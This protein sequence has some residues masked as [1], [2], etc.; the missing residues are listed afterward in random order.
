MKIKD[1]EITM[2]PAGEGDCIVVYFED[3]NYRILIDGGV[4]STYEEN[5]RPYLQK[6][7]SLE[8][9]ID[10]IVVTHIDHDHLG[11]IIR[12]LKENGKADNPSLISIDEI[13]FNGLSQL[14]KKITNADIIPQAEKG[15]LLG[16]AA[17]NC[18]TR[19]ESSGTRDISFSQGE[20]LS[21]LIINNGYAWNRAFNYMPV[22]KGSTVRIGDI[23][24]TI[25][26]PTINTLK[27]LYEKWIGELK[28]RCSNVVVTD[29]ILY[30]SAFE[31]F[32]LYE[33]DD[34]I[35]FHT[36][37]S[38]IKN[39]NWEKEAEKEDDGVDSSL[40][41]KSSIVMRIEYKG[42]YLLFPGD[43]PIRSIADELPE[44]LDVVKLPHHGSGRSIDKN[45]IKNKKV[46]YYLLSTNGKKHNHP[47]K[48]IIGNVLLYSKIETQIIKNYNLEVL[49]N[50][51]VLEDG[52]E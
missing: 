9:K 32:Y 36:I 48:T 27:K 26:N 11:G 25:L 8:Q 30:D 51:G 45:F 44:Y 5:L 39:I 14:P 16:M 35:Q 12:L 42:H 7:S 21:E 17:N 1:I 24:I 41:N 18:L 46:S 37:S 22:I 4:S 38:S 13:W 40:T 49:E 47:S 28:K 43:Y 19:I 34:E 50:I 3:Q 23:A 33:S 52:Y 29:D 2:L 20:C 31:G 6:L 15:I 10:L